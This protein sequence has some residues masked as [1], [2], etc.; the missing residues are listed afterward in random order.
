MEAAF[1]PPPTT[2][3]CNGTALW[4]SQK[5]TILALWQEWAAKTNI[6]TE[7]NQT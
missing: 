1:T 7:A 4:Q 5:S 6:A 2:Q 3:K